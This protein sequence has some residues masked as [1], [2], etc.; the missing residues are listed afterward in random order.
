MKIILKKK[1]FQS[2]NILPYVNSVVEALCYKWKVVGS[3]PDEVGFFQF[4]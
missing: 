3:S 2:Q 1:N 4:T